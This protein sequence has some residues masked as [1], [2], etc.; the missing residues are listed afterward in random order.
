MCPM[1]L[2]LE[3]L[4]LNKKLKTSCRKG[5]TVGKPLLDF[6]CSSTAQ[7]S[8]SFPSLSASSEG[9]GFR[10]DLETNEAQIKILFNKMSSR[11]LFLYMKNI[12]TYTVLLKW[13]VHVI[14]L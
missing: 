11:I 4:F 13:C 9:F 10:Y 6:E 5:I 7:C 12:P 8:A 14:F 2:L 3:P 1:L